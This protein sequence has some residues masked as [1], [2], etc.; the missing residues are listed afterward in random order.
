MEE[1]VSHRRDVT[2]VEASGWEA[3]QGSLLVEG[4]EEIV[5]CCGNMGGI[6]TSC[7][8]TYEG[9]SSVECVEKVISY[10]RRTLSKIGR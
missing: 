8:D 1:G 7:W 2:R 5:S 10:I 3:G 6:K 4:R 9:T